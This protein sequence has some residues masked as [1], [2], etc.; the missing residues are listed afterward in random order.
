MM[1][2]CC[3]NADES[4][5]Y[6][7]QQANLT[8]PASSRTGLSTSSYPTASPSPHS[9]QLSISSSSSGGAHVHWNSASANA[10]GGG[11]SVLSGEA[12]SEA[13][14]VATQM[15]YVTSYSTAEFRT[16]HRLVI[17][18]GPTWSS[19]SPSPHG[20][21]DGFGDL[22][23]EAPNWAAVSSSGALI[24]LVGGRRAVEDGIIDRWNYRQ[25]SHCRI[26]PG[27][28]PVT[29]NPENPKNAR[30]TS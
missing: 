25:V 26:Y 3:K 11:R 23:R 8:S 24:F 9:K 1:D 17:D 20:D 15:H 18:V 28:L 12:G 22:V 5:T 30:A 29:N 27:T 16:F 2:P 7:P 6:A 14:F 21:S 13:G 10:S 4:R 19:S